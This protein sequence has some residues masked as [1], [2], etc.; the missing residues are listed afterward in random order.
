MGGSTLIAK[1][2]VLLSVAGIIVLDV[3]L[4]AGTFGMSYSAYLLILC[5]KVAFDL[6]EFV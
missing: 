3:S 4:F 1:T 6:T 2:V 5:A